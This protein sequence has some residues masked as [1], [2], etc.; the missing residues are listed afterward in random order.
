ML[1]VDEYGVRDRERLADVVRLGLDREQRYDY[2]HDIVETVADGVG[3]PYVLIDVLL[4]HAQIILDGVG[5]LPEW[6]AKAGGTPM[7]WAFC[8]PLVSGRR[9]HS[10]TDLSLD[11]RFKANPMVRMEHAR[12]YAG[13]PMIS[14]EGQ[15]LG[16]LCAIDVRPHEFTGG[17]L[18]LLQEMADEVV[19]RLEDHAPIT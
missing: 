6:I 8:A 2:L 17:N 4:D 16:G 13:A 15:V 18:R 19:H 5:P 14:M 7:E 11:D 12:A 1:T 3:T 10:V 9:A